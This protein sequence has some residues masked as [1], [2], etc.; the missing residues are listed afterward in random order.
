MQKQLQKL[1][2]QQQKQNV[3]ILMRKQ[4]SKER[5]QEPCVETTGE[6]GGRH[7]GHPGLHTV[8]EEAGHIVF[9]TEHVE[10]DMN[11]DTGER[12]KTMHNIMNANGEQTDIVIENE[13]TEAEAEGV[14][15]TSTETN[16]E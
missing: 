14:E 15:G 9:H 5:A 1:R 8:N 3:K 4:K 11:D 13:T 16:V 6:S 10:H 2:M 7:P 12:T